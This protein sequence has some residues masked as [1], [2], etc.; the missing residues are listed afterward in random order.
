M[1]TIHVD[2]VSAEGH[3]F[4]G[5]ASLVVADGTE[6]QIGIAP[7][8][9]PL[10]T[11]LVPGEIRVLREGDP[12][13]VFYVSGGI[14]EVQPQ[15]VT[16]LADTAVRGEEIDEQ[17]AAEDRRRAEQAMKS[18]VQKDDIARAQRELIEAA[19]RYRVRQRLRGHRSEK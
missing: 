6:G 19:A 11:V 10:L 18:A 14:L 13:L 2:I 16:V 7:R 4:S 8:H 1:A 9:A 3:V 15:R 12:E 17:A 5:P